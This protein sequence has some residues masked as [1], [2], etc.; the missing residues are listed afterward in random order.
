MTCPGSHSKFYRRQYENEVPGFLLQFYCKSQF[1]LASPQV[2]R[3]FALY[4]LAPKGIHA[5]RGTS[6]LG[7]RKPHHF[8]GLPIL[9]T[10]EVDKGPLL[11]RTTSDKQTVN[12]SQEPPEVVRGYQLVPILLEHEA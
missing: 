8:N 1:H 7:T 11:Q 4:T 10:T 2:R 6:P 3:A 5:D 12:Y 9:V